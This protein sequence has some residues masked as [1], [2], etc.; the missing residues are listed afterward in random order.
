LSI[1]RNNDGHDGFLLAQD[2]IAP[3]IRAFL[4]EHD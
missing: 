2:A 3:I 4:E 1:I